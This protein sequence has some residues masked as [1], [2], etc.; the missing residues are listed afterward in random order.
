MASSYLWFKAL[1]VAFMVTWFAGLTYLPRL[2]L[3]HAETDDAPG[4]ERFQA[5]EMRLFVLMTVGAAV[6][7]IFGYLLIVLNTALV[8]ETWF[9]VKLL[10]VVGLAVY[11]YRCYRWMVTL[12]AETAP[13][14]S[15]R[16]S[17]F[18][19]VP[20]AFLLAIVVLAVAKPF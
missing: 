18:G 12:R 20:A 15:G 5:M 11:H 19:H 17:A 2:L 16:L 10:L 7:V 3:A 8:A 4:R 14:D 13:R 6:T 9:R 1:H